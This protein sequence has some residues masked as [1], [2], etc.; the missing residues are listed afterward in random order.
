M[1]CLGNGP[2][3]IDPQLGQTFRGWQWNGTQWVCVNA[4]A[5]IVTQVFTA[6]GVYTPSTGMT[7]ALVECIGGGGGGGNVGNANPSWILTAGGGGSGGYSK[8]TVSA[9][10]VRGGVVV[11]VG[12]G[13]AGNNPGQPTSFGALCVANGGGIGGANDA[14][15]QKD[16]KSVV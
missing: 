15:A 1:N 12:A 16:R 2:F 14:G 13:G 10:L 6:S 4:N 7:S 5:R 11:T 8:R 3:P 9:A